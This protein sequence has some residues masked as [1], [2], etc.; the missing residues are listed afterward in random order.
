MLS[1]ATSRL[2]CSALALAALPAAAFADDFNSGTDAAWTRFSPLGGFGAAG[3]FSFPDGHYRIAAPSS[4]LPDVVG[5]GRAGSLFGTETYAD[6]DISVDILDLGSSPVN[7]TIGLLARVRDIGLGSTDGYAFL[8]D[9]RGK[10]AL[11]RFDNEVDLF[12]QNV[13]FPLDVGGSYRLRLTGIGSEFTGTVTNLASPGTPILTLTGSDAA[14]PDGS[15]GLLAYNDDALGTAGA[16]GTFDNF[17]AAAVPEP[18][19]YALLGL[20]LAAL[21]L[22]RRR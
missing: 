4:P 11:L 7:S 10:V 17:S 16:M 1:S 19:T 20:G 2:A 15:V 6:F 8:Y 18:S 13:V 14:F 22:A 9:A 12:M 21:A 5:P 3:V